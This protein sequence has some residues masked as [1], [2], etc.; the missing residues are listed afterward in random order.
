MNEQCFTD[1]FRGKREKRFAVTSL[2]A[3]D[4][5]R[6]EWVFVAG[7]ASTCLATAAIRG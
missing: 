2:P 7:I 3:Y 1:C 4:Q 6:S 5:S